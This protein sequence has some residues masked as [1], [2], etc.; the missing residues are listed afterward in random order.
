MRK[1]REALLRIPAGELRRHQNGRAERDGTADLAADAHVGVDQLRAAHRPCRACQTP[2]QAE[3]DGQPQQQR[4]GDAGIDD[5]GDQPPI[6]RYSSFCRRHDS[7]ARRNR[8]R[9]LRGLQHRDVGRQEIIRHG[10]R[11]E[12]SG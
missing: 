1:H 7:R 2:G 11:R 6:D 5:G 8:Q 3:T 4:A 12:A 10:Y 9:R